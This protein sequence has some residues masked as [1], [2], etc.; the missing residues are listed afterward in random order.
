MRPETAPSP[1]FRHLRLNQEMEFCIPEISTFNMNPG[2]TS[3]LHDTAQEGKTFHFW[4]RQDRWC[5]NF[6]AR[7]S[8]VSLSKGLNFHVSCTNLQAVS[9]WFSSGLEAVSKS[10]LK[11]LHLESMQILK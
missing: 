2:I 5:V 8:C 4:L 3:L 6:S 10:F 7:L 11:A 1:V 9:K